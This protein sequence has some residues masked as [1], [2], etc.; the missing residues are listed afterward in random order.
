[1]LREI[2]VAIGIL[3]VTAS[4]EIVYR[5]AGTLSFVAFLEIWVLMMW[6]MVRLEKKTNKAGL[7]VFWFVCLPPATALGMVLC[8][9]YYGKY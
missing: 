1:M 2:S 6:I 9:I 7:F 5:I 4:L 3:V 8:Q